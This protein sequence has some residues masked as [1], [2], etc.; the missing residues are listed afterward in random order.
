MAVE[1]NRN[2]ANVYLATAYVVT[3]VLQVVTQVED[4]I[5]CFYTIISCRFRFMSIFPR[6]PMDLETLILPVDT[7][8]N[9]TMTRFY[10]T[11]T[12]QIVSY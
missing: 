9:N 1:S 5:R 4:G 7:S 3:R 12:C 6:K 10:K 8:V 11:R 2:L